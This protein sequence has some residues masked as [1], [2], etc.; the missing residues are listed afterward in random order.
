MWQPHGKVCSTGKPAVSKIGGAFC[1]YYV[2][3]PHVAVET[4]FYGH[5]RL[6]VADSCEDRYLEVVTSLSL[7]F[8]VQCWCRE[9]GSPLIC[10]CAP[11]G[12]LIYL[13]R[14]EHVHV[15][16]KNYVI[17]TAAVSFPRYLPRRHGHIRLI[18]WPQTYRCHFYS[19][20]C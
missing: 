3:Y 9:F 11:P 2:T 6:H 1:S 4:R 19:V 13:P 15:V 10:I 16:H 12:L 17:V 7:G 14:A 20:A 8:D 5:K 18:S